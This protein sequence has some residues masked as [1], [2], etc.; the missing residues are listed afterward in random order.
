MH[1]MVIYLLTVLLMTSLLSLT[2]CSKEASQQQTQRAAPTSQPSAQQA[3]PASQPTQA[4]SSAQPTQPAATPGSKVPGTPAT[5]K[6]T[7]SLSNYARS[8]V[9]VSVNG[10]WVGQWDAHANAPLDSV[11]QGKNE[12]TVEVKEEPKNEVRLEIDAERGG[13]K[14][15]LLRLNFLGKTGTFTYNFIAR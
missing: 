6:H 1:K 10:V 11:V 3:A 2:S 13:Q 4:T 15:N 5:E 14:V 8:P 12:L 9:I 7:M